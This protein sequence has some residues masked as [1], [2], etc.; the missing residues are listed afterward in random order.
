MSQVVSQVRVF[1]LK[2]GARSIVRVV[3]KPRVSLQYHL[4]PE[5][6]LRSQI[7]THLYRGLVR[8]SSVSMRSRVLY[9]MLH[10]LLGGALL[11]P[12]VPGAVTSGRETPVY[13]IKARIVQV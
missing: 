2:C 3:L 4:A 7:A 5:L 9:L 12:G 6:S 8:T 1:L 11:V 10:F 13:P